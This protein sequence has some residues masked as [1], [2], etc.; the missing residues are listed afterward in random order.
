MIRIEIDMDHVVVEGKKVQRPARIPRSE[1]MKRWE[2]MRQYDLVL[3][4]R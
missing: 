3:D 2:A 4:R 1:W